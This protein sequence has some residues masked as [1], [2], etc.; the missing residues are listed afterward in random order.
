MNYI[1]ISWKPDKRLKI[2]AY[3]QIVEYI[4]E[5]ISSGDWAIG[6]K[7]PSQRQLA[8]LFEVNRSTVVTAMEE[9]LSYD[10]IESDFS[11]GTFIKNNTWS[12]LISSP[13]NWQNYV[14][15][16]SFKANWETVTILNDLCSNPE[17]I[18]L[19]MGELPPNLFPEEIADS[20]GNILS[21]KYKSLNYL[22]ALGSEELRLELSKMLCKKGIM[23]GPKNILV[24]SGSVQ[25]L[26]LISVGMLKRG[27]Y[28]Y[29]ESPSYIRSLQIFDSNGVGID[30]VPM[31]EEG[32]SSR[33]IKS[34]HRGLKTKPRLLYTIPNFQSP[35][36][37]TM[38]AERRKDLLRFCQNERLPIIEDDAYGGLYF[39][40]PPPPSLKSM[41]KSG[42][43]LY[44]GTLSTILAPGLRVGWVVG[45]ESV[46]SRLSDI[47]MQIDYG[48]SS[49]SQAIACK[50]LK[51]FDYEAYLVG[52]RNTIKSKRDHMIKELDQHLSDYA[53]WKEPKGGVHLWLTFN[54][55]IDLWQLFKDAISE[56]LIIAPGYIY[57]LGKSQSIR[58]TYSYSDFGEI[59]QGIQILKRAVQK[60]Y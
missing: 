23:A 51:D 3:R 7:L 60:Q 27:D 30:W 35:M 10:L 1:K 44:M 42:M 9:L 14:D 53:V 33:S 47:K 39:D 16:G 24:T 45:A 52:V 56:K 41:D 28:I 17:Y 38:S 12:L 34:K 22:E 29:S 31:D 18:D 19:G 40:G 36:G 49:L 55:K 48:A 25:A 15:S 32:L 43:V 6:Q 46:I 4:T 5:K 20:V 21:E 8:E 26:H 54:R 59:S 57:E 13:P 58:L 2:P 11:N 37:I 50:F